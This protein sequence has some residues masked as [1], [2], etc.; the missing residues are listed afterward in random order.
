MKKWLAGFTLIELLVVIAIIAILVGLLLPALARAREEG[1]RTKC[2][3]N[4]EQIGRASAAYY[5]NAND[6]WPVYS[7]PA[8]WRRTLGNVAESWKPYDYKATDSLSLLY[9]DYTGIVGIFSCP[10]TGDRA[11]IALARHEMMI[12]KYV[13]L[14]GGRA[15]NLT[16]GGVQRRYTWFGDAGGRT[17]TT[18]LW[19]SYGYDD[20][21][22]HSQ[23]G[24]GHVV[25]GDMDDT[26]VLGTSNTSNHLGG[27]NFLY[28][29]GHVAFS[30]VNFASNNP[31]DHVF[32]AEGAGWGQD[33]DSYLRRP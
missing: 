21:I 5:G 8:F 28:F 11:T 33:T 23:S 4:L 14:S 29:D 12:Y 27:C 30:R 13:D 3:S 19:S 2:K 20:K 7:P 32:K 10:S 17:K 1:R 16:S 24:A 26:A 6:Y 31:L 15:S 25:V 22:H 18:P 9:P